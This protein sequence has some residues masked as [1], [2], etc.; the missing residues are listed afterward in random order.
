MG[1]MQG[2]ALTHAL[3]KKYF[4]LAERFLKMGADPNKPKRDGVSPLHIA[5]F[6]E[7]T[8]MVKRLIMNKSDLDYRVPSNMTGVNSPWSVTRSSGI[9]SHP[10]SNLS[11]GRSVNHPSSAIAGM[12]ALAFAAN[13]RNS[14]LLRMLLEAG[15]LPN[16]GSSGGVSA[17]HQIARDI[18][19]ASQ[20][21]LNSSKAL[22]EDQAKLL[23][24]LTE[25]GGDPDREVS[26]KTVWDY[27]KCF[28]EVHRDIIKAQEMYRKREKRKED[29]QKEN[30]MKTA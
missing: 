17:M 10:L 19:E 29:E 4:N 25:Y 12:N 18:Y 2:T 23:K 5:T 28:P 14:F 8:T 7:H 6:I 24:L 16:N 15:A 27:T 26:G 20:K 1:S 21:T 11:L 22:V 3:E 30:D 9:V 13:K